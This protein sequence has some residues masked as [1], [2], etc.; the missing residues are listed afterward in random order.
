M[1]TAQLDFLGLKLLGLGLGMLGLGWYQLG[2][3]Q[4]LGSEVWSR[5]CLASAGTP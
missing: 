1:D 4:A 2:L 3:G 5:G